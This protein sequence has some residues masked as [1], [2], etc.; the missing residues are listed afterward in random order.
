MAKNKIKVKKSDLCIIEQN[1]KEI[2]NYINSDDF[3]MN[4]SNEKLVNNVF[5]IRKISNKIKKKYD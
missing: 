1:I 2:A 5:E 3:K 4:S